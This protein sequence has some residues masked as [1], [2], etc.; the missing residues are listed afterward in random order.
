MAIKQYK[1][2]FWDLDGTIINSY[3]GVVESA[4]YALKHFGLTEDNPQILRRFIGPPLRV[5]FGEFY[6]MD[7]EQIEEAVRK[8]RENYHAG[9]MFKC[10]PYPGVK[11]AM[12]AFNAAGFK[13]IIASSKP[14]HMCRM[15]LERFGLI[16]KMDDIV[17]ASLDGR[18][19]TKQEVLEEAFRRLGNPD[20]SEVVLIGDTKYDAIGAKTVD[21]DCIGITYGFGTR[22][23]LIE[24]GA[25]QV[26]DTIDEVV[27][28]LCR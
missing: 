11:E 28:V 18:I 22:E 9:G 27:E 8:Y 4:L 14:E 17:G 5:T 1:Y 13:Q 2:I 15:I 26:Y 7:E 3:P 24:H 16:E 23:E 21:I 20:K 19:D 12:D 10:E 6:D 25:C